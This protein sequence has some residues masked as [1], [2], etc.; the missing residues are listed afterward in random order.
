M[1]TYI[2]YIATLLAALALP[3]NGQTGIPVTKAAPDAP[4]MPYKLSTTVIGN[5]HGTLAVTDN[6]E[7]GGG[8]VFV[9]N[10]TLVYGANN[11]KNAT[12]VKLT[13]TLKANYIPRSDYPKAYRTNDKT[14]LI[15]LDPVEDPSTAETKVYT[16]YMPPYPV[17]IE[18]A[19]A[20]PIASVDAI[21]LKAQAAS[22]TD[23]IALLPAYIPVTLANGQKESLA[24][25]STG[26]W[27][28]KA[29]GDTGT[30]T[31]TYDPHG[32]AVNRFTAT[33]AANALPDSI[34]K[35]TLLTKAGATYTAEVLVVNQAEPLAPIE[36]DKGLT[37]LPGTGDNL[38]GK[39]GDKEVPFNGT[40][41]GAEVPSLK[42]DGGVKDA[43][44]TL[45][46]VTVSGG[47]DPEGSKTEVE[48][49]ADLTIRIE[50][51]NNLGTLAIGKDASVVLD[52]AEGATL[53]GTSV[54][55]DGTFRDSTATIPTVTGDGALSISGT[56]SGGG[57][58]T[59][60]TPVTLTA[61]TTDRAGTTTFIWQK[62][63]ADGSYKE[64]RKQA[65][66]EDGTPIQTRSGSAAT[67]NGIVDTYS[68]STSATGISEYRCLIERT[69]TIPASGG[70]GEATTATTLLSTQPAKVEVWSDSD[71][72]PVTSYTV[73]LPALEGFSISPAPGQHSVEEGY[74][75]SFTLTPA[76]GND[77]PAPTVT[78]SRGETL[79]PRPSDGLYVI[80]GIYEDI[81]V[82]FTSQPTA[83]EEITPADEQVSVRGT[84]GGVRIQTTRP[85]T[86]T[87]HTLSGRPVTR[88]I[89]PA[90]ESRVGLPSGFYIIRV[91]NESRKAIV[92]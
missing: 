19:Y 4:A 86:A 83:N 79:T 8:V 38:N 17:T 59:T 74:D 51:S 80:N 9:G 66:K 33:L 43:T 31:A 92:R 73:T 42:V 16:F 44:L 11:K 53:E 64:V 27:A 61:S 90:G 85:A 54:S 24:V 26:G 52:K 48:T 49:G 72:E 10:D 68:P 3:A 58:F 63:E 22:E 6:E 20:L 50:G 57:S 29:S 1:K 12:T 32:G 81:T 5:A 69:V 14:T 45:K 34:D 36:T 35:G 21:T 82:R 77:T 75:F 7:G 37:I 46:G 28:F 56:L 30:G 60:N 18:T 39:I 2:I 55:N 62:R 65:Y 91:G 87:V 78:T 25:A 15:V 67:D 47:S 23:A 71:P 13:L 41:E 89:L 40:I 84:R 76:E 88:M 70:S